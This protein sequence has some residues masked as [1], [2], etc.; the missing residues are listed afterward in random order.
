KDVLGDHEIDLCQQLTVNRNGNFGGSHG[1]L[2]KY[3][4]TSYHNCG[5]LSRRNRAR[6]RIDREKLPRWFER[7]VILMAERLAYQPPRARR[8]RFQNT[9]DLMRAAVGCSGGFGA[10]VAVVRVL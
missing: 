4:K 8:R 10:P 3:D 7:S 9:H 2:R 5:W 6:G 1:C